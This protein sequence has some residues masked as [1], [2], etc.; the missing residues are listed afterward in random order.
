LDGA[1][2]LSR[3]V[4]APGRDTIDVSDRFGMYERRRREANHGVSF[5]NST[6]TLVQAAA[7]G[8]VIAAGEDNQ[9][10]FGRFPGAYGNLVILQHSLPGFAEPV[11]TLYAHLSQVS[12]TID[13]EV[14][15]GQEI[16]RVGS[17]G[18]V[19]G[20]TL[21]F[22]VRLGE[23]TYAAVRNPELWLSNLADENG[24]S[25]GVL[26]G[27]VLDAQGTD[28]TVGN[29]QVE[30]LGAPGQ[31]AVETL[32][33]KTYAEKRL[34]GLGPWGESFAAGD[35]PAGSY[36]ISFWLGGLQQRVVQVEPGRLTFVTFR[37]P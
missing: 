13:Q 36:Q 35:L 14:T 17:S 4:A 21:H 9:A 2:L 22:E 34:V 5:L 26:A 37:I 32:Y 11:F 16:G 19:R 24:Q 15:A 8:R 29:I 23:N 12:V 25:Y 31:P 28:L 6:G 33:L 30:R 1:F 7:A 20:S 3:P 18:S 27:R 10:I